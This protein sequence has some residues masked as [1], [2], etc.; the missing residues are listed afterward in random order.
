MDMTDKNAGDN[1]TQ[2]SETLESQKAALAA[3]QEKQLNSCIQQLHQHQQRLY[4]PAALMPAHSSIFGAGVGATLGHPAHPDGIATYA[5]ARFHPPPIP[6]QQS[7]IDATNVSHTIAHQHS[8]HQPPHLQHQP[9]PTHAPPTV[10]T[11]PAAASPNV[12][13]QSGFVP[14]PLLPGSAGA[15]TAAAT[16]VLTPNPF[17]VTQQLDHLTSHW[18][19]QQQLEL[20]K[21]INAMNT[22]VSAVCTAGVGGNNA[23]NLASQQQATRHI[24]TDVPMT[25][26]GASSSSSGDGTGAMSGAISSTI[27]ENVLNA[28]SATPNSSVSS[29]VPA[30]HGRLTGI[31]VRIPDDERLQHIQEVVET[32]LSELAKQQIQQIADRIATLKPVEKLLLYLRLPGETPETDPLRHPQNPLGTRSEIN[33]TINWV[34]SH[35]EHDPKVSIPKQDVYNDYIAYCDRL[36][37]KPLSTADFG[38]VMKQ[39]FPG[40]RPRRLGTRGHSRYC[41]AAMRKTTKLDAP[42]LPLLDTVAANESSIISSTS[43]ADLQNDSGEGIAGKETWEIIRS[44]AEN[45]LH[46]KVDSAQELASCIKNTVSG[47]NE[48]TA[49]NARTA[50]GAV[51]KK[52]TPREPKE[53]RLMADMGPLKKRRKR[54]RKGSSSSESTCS[55]P[56][57]QTQQHS[58]TS[59]VDEQAVDVKPAIKAE[60]VQIK[61]E[62]LESPTMQR[63]QHLPAAAP[64]LPQMATVTDNFL[65]QQQQQQMLPMNLVTEQ[66]TVLARAPPSASAFGVVQAQPQTSQQRQPVR[67]ALVG[68]PSSTTAVKNLTPKII[69]LGASSSAAG[70]AN[71]VHEPTTVIKEEEFLD[72]YNPN[73]FCKKVRKAQQTKGFWANSPTSVSSNVVVPTITT[74]APASEVVALSTS[75]AA[76]A[77][78]VIATSAMS[79]SHS[80]ACNQDAGLTPTDLMGPPAQIGS[81]P[82]VSPSNSILGADSSGT[83]PQPPTAASPKVLSRN[84]LQMRAKRQQI[85]AALT[86]EA[87]AN[88]SNNL[89]D[90]D[91]S[92]LPANLGLP[93]E[94]VISICNMDKHELD[95]YFVADE[96]EEEPEDQETELLQYFQ[97]RDAEEKL[98]SLDAIKS[99]RHPTA[100]TQAAITT[101]PATTMSTV[102]VSTALAKTPTLVTKSTPQIAKDV[103]RQQSAQIVATDGYSYAS[104]L[105]NGGFTASA[106]NKKHM[107]LGTTATKAA[108]PTTTMAVGS[109]SASL[110]FMSQKHQQQQHHQQQMHSQTRKGATQQTLATSHINNNKRKISLSGPTLNAAEVMATRKNCIFFPISPNSNTGSGG[111][112]GTKNIGN[113][114]NNKFKGSNASLNTANMSNSNNGNGGGGSFFVSPGQSAHRVRPKPTFALGKQ[115][116]LDHD[117]SDPMIGASRRRRS[118]ANLVISGGSNS[119]IP[120]S[121]A[122]APPSPSVLQQQQQFYGA[123]FFNDTMTQQQ[124]SNNSAGGAAY[125]Q[126]NSNTTVNA[127][128]ILAADQNSLDLDMFSASA[129]RAMEYDDLALDELTTP[130]NEMQRSQ[131]VPLSQ[132]QRIHSPAFNRSFIN[133]PYSACTSVAQTPVPHEFADSSTLFS[134]NSCSETSGGASGG[135]NG[136]HSAQVVAAKLLDDEA[137]LLATDTAAMLDNLDVAEMFPADFLR[138]KFPNNVQSNAATTT[139]SS[140]GSSSGYSSSAC[141]TFGSAALI[142]GTGVN[143]LLGSTG[144][145]MSRS[146]P[147]TPLPHQQ[148]SPFASY[149]YGGRRRLEEEVHLSPSL[150]TPG[151]TVGGTFTTTVFKYG[152]NGGGSVEGSGG[153]VNNNYD[154][155]RSMPTTPTATPRFRYSPTEFTREFL[156]NGNTNTID[157]LISGSA[158][159]GS[160]T[161]AGAPSEGLSAALTGLTGNNDALID[162][163]CGLSTDAFVN[164]TVADAESMMAESIELLGNL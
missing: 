51:H 82:S 110:T 63:I 70:P 151:K 146:V 100:L 37:I 11:A 44:W 15:V 69:E 156:S 143:S 2:W 14:P 85:I 58:T 140:A 142:S 120:L 92:D 56:Q 134:E 24:T 22:Q 21:I 119:L 38:K 78:S 55:Q 60:L 135:M 126:L 107:A 96:V 12:P 23:G 117:S 111:S 161:D 83:T 97:T 32:G 159:A 35:L 76:V 90:G 88:A 5:S 66:R 84:M 139:C 124:C 29:S 16:S 157:S 109:A 138:M 103:G 6:T 102:V 158:N 36:D 62:I 163:S 54:K 162:D 3:Q 52:Y 68:L 128:D 108:N 123:G 28:I 72:E 4:D 71:A 115:L 27:A 40:I 127:A 59:A 91:A 86:A 19:L 133:A 31:G 18:N 164:H 130:L 93:R 89:P 50:G 1:G 9:S 152:N 141:T 17:A 113:N 45:V 153:S 137:A 112:N 39:V 42:Q 41:Y 95:D 99:S 125:N 64:Q 47:G 131:S 160:L 48:L 13:V 147:S 25:N 75:L 101:M 122:S 94:R 67:T 149:F 87:A 53:K 30:V 74:T 129:G 73:I 26:V 65:Q 104:Q 80:S 106:R 20:N 10:L 118:Y 148:Q 132:L 8:Q 43:S 98:N 61:Q 136:R 155:S 144:N 105:S 121:S 145:T 57:A 77:T 46:V 81:N 79:S 154:M 34:R 7:T 49:T 33:H 150:T 114:T 116:S